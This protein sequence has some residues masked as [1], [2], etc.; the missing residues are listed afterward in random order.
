[1][2]ILASEKFSFLA[3]EPQECTQVYVI[4]FGNGLKGSLMLYWDRVK[5]EENTV[6]FRLETYELLTAKYIPL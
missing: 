6:N 5:I 1:M 3:S 2:P 4:F